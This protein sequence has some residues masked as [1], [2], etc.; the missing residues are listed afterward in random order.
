MSVALAGASESEVAQMYGIDSRE[1]LVAELPTVIRLGEFA[2]Y[3]GRHYMVDRAHHGRVID[4]EDENGRLARYFGGSRMEQVTANM[5]PREY[6]GPAAAR[7]AR[8]MINKYSAVD[9]DQNGGKALILVDADPR[10][11]PFAE[12]QWV[13][14]Q[15]ARL[16]HGARIAGNEGAIRSIFAPDMYT[17][18]PGVIDHF[19]RKYRKITNDPFYLGSA[20]GKSLEAGGNE[21]RPDATSWS[22]FI[23]LEKASANIEIPGRDY[24]SVKIQ[25]A[26]NVG[27]PF[28]K[29][30]SGKRS[31]YEIT[32]ISDYYDGVESTISVPEGMGGMAFTEELTK[33]L[34]ANPD[35]DKIAAIRE[36]VQKHQ[37]D[38]AEK[39][40]ISYKP[41]A[42]LEVGADWL[43]LAA[44]G[45]VLTA[46]TVPDDRE[47]VDAIARC[48]VIEGAN[49]AVSEVAHARLVKY[50]KEDVP[51]AL[52]NPGGTLASRIEVADNL[53]V[54]GAK[55]GYVETQRQI[56]SILNA[57][58]GQHEKF[59]AMLGTTDRR[60]GAV[61]Y[62]LARRAVA[63]GVDL[64]SGLRDFFVSRQAA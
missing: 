4:P 59:M 56:S 9:V 53:S 8:G 43:V 57:A 3:H 11:I 19:A 20:A 18:D 63:H 32:A 10:K 14:G 12:K 58:W 13:M 24:Q 33:Q 26:G 41:G 61:V 35:Q 37:P 60:Q 16:A 46:E 36:Y 29:F 42:I 5:N 40:E 50:G 2:S 62:S 51:G 38:L 27:L 21:F 1:L 15:V 34:L 31:K 49:H 47:K 7:L 48:G 6:I 44:K 23:A 52:A 30:A 25:G 54:I 45:D 22:V 55:H 39:I 28:A 17:G 64:D